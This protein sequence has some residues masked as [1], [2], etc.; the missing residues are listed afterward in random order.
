MTIEDV[1]KKYREKVREMI[2]D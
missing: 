2:N 1:P